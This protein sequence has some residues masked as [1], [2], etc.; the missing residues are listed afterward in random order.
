MII[1]ILKS[2]SILVI[3]TLALMLL[4]IG[5]FIYFRSARTK[6]KKLQKYYANVK[7]AD[8]QLSTNDGP[9]PCENDAK[10]EDSEI[11]ELSKTMFLD[12]KEY[13]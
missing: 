4:I 8:F 10:I 1:S 3:F 9:N 6:I 13:V 11:C 12:K 5:M 7:P 2:E